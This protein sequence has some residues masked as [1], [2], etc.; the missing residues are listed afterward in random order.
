[1]MLELI[2]ITNYMAKIKFII[3]FKSLCRSN[4]SNDTSNCYQ[5]LN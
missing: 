2:L 5:S 4:M 3:E 1:M